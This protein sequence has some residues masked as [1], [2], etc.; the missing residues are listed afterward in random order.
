MTPLL[1][2]AAHRLSSS[3]TRRRRGGRRGRAAAA[4]RPRS[5]SPRCW[6][7]DIALTRLLAAYG[8]APDIVMGHSLGEYGALVAA[9]RADVRRRARGG[10]RPR[11]ARWPASRSRTTA[12][13]PPCSPRS[14][15]S[16]A[17]WRRSTAT[18]SSP[19]S[20][21]RSQAVIGGA[22][23]GGRA[24]PSPRFS[25][26][27]HTAD[28][29]AGEPRLPHLDR[30]PGQRAAAAGAA[31]ASTSSRRRCPIVANVDGELYPM[32]PSVQDQMLDILAR[33]VA[34]PV[35]F[36][37][38]PATRSTRRARACSSRSARS[39]RSTASS[40]TCSARSTTTW[41]PCSPT[42][43][44]RATSWRSTRRCAG[45]T[46]PASA[47]AAEAPAAEPSHRR[48]RRR[49]DSARRR[50]ASPPA[51]PRRRSR[52]C[53]TTATAELGHLLADFLERSRSVWE[54]RRRCRPA[55]AAGRERPAGAGG[56]SPARRS[57]LPGTERVFDDG[58]LGRILDGEQF[59]DL[60]PQ[61]I[62]EAMV[63]KH[64]TRLVK[65]ED[66][67]ARFETHRQRR[68]RHQA[69]RPRR[70]VRPRRGVRRRRRPR[71]GARRLTR[72]WRSA[73]ASTRC[74]TPASRSCMHYKT[75]TVGHASCPSAGGCPTRCATTPA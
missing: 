67:G 16:S 24:R 64:I 42:I 6:P 50:A 33:Q 61:S 37:E 38:G 55:T 10:E 3:S 58:N 34:S 65:S 48:R 73:P 70:R 29:A 12:R 56:R 57:G 19:T 21:A 68:R 27:G 8:I 51:T 13:W 53:P 62:R 4:A 15:R 47:R 43:R 22:T 35:Q 74:A 32:G 18:S 5:P 14:R 46:P 60:I 49:A 17:S 2:Q 28:P 20:T 36:V 7:I 45:C 72:S 69:G 63:D 26:A 44:S 54:G 25:D 9:G 59:I 41:S 52:R 30:R 75:T 71:Q 66:G 40:T 39:R 11:A 1:G 23:D 31:R